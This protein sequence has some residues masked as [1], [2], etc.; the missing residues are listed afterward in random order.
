MQRA[1]SK[2]RPLDGSYTHPE[3]DHPVERTGI[4]RAEIKFAAKDCGSREEKESEGIEAPWQCPTAAIIIGEPSCTGG[5]GNKT[6][7]ENRRT[8]N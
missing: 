8:C 6:R 3:E 1:P 5:E 7:E 4:A 2:R